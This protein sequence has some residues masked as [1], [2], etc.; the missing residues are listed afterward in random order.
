MEAGS[1]TFLVRKLEALKAKKYKE[2]EILV[3]ALRRRSVRY[4]NLRQRIRIKTAVVG[5]SAGITWHSFVEASPAVV[6]SLAQFPAELF[7]EISPS[8][9][10]Q[11]ATLPPCSD[12]RSHRGKA[13]SYWDNCVCGKAVASIVNDLVL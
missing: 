9:V 12:E 11:R 1:K 10:Q 6:K 2:R 3:G 8:A 5:T 7:V 13:T 4:C